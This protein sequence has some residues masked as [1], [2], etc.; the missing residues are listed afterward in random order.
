MVFKVTVKLAK[1]TQTLPDI[2]VSNFP[3]FRSRYP[4]WESAN[5]KLYLLPRYPPDMLTRFQSSLLLGDACDKGARGEMGRR[6]QAKGGYR[7]SSFLLPV[8]PHAPLSRASPNK[9]NDWERV[10]ETFANV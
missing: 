2:L 10:R 7:L 9:R 8:T 1:I 4:D 6:I 3:K 5:E